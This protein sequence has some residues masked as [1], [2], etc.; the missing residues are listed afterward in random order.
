MFE[1]HYIDTYLF[2]QQVGTLAVFDRA[3]LVFVRS[4]PAWKAR[5]LAAVHENNSDLASDLIHQMKGT[6]AM[7]CAI[8]LRDHLMEMERKLRSGQS[9]TLSEAL[10]PL[11][12]LLAE[13]ES[14]LRLY[15]IG[16]QAP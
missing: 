11:S 5:L 9:G 2:K 6:S 1:P 4:I 16:G 8:P 14:E 7:M 3:A 13:T 10:G 15:W 12:E